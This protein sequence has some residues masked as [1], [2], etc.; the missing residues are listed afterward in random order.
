MFHLMPIFWPRL[1]HKVIAMVATFPYWK[2]EY[3]VTCVGRQRQRAREH[4][5]H[6]VDAP[7][8]HQ[9]AHSSGKGCPAAAAVERSPSKIRDASKS[10]SRKIKQI[11]IHSVYLGKSFPPYEK[12]WMT[13]LCSLMLSFLYFMKFCR[14]IS[15]SSM[16]GT[17]F[18]EVQVS[19]AT[20]TI[21]VFSCSL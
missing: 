19:M 16:T 6:L 10:I 13:S 18:L 12:S 7:S 21:L 9:R 5:P 8:P 1:W 11:A 15:G 20:S 17:L 3:M 2:R 4:S 14:V